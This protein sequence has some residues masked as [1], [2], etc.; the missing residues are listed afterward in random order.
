MTDGPPPSVFFFLIGNQLRLRRRF[1]EEEICPNSKIPGY[2]VPPFS[3][4]GT[5]GICL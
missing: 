3:K 1:V 4:G 5:G 2:W